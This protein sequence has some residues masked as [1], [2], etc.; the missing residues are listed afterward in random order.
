MHRCVN[1][2][3]VPRSWVRGKFSWKVA[4]EGIT[5]GVR[6][7]D[8]LM[9]TVTHERRSRERLRRQIRQYMCQYF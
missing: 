9:E 1:I 6:G 2:P 5:P 7:R 8:E 3:H 4:Q